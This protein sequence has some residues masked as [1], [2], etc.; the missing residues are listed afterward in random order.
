M[1]TFV[2]PRELSGMLPPIT[3]EEVI[4][5][6]RPPA[7]KPG[8]LGSIAQAWQ[9][10]NVRMSLAQVGLGLMRTPQ[11][12]QNSF[13]TASEALGLGLNTLQS[14]REQERQKKLQAEDRA[15]KEQQRQIENKRGDRQV[16]VQER[17]ATTAETNVKGDQEVKTKE[18]DRANR[19]LDEAIRHNK[20]QEEIDRLR[21][22]ADNLR[23]TAYYGNTQRTPAEIQ[24][25]NR[26]KAFYKQQDPNISDEIADKMAM[27]YLSTAKGK[28]PRQL[29][30]DAY[31]K[32]AQ[33]WM[34]QQYD[35][36]AQPTPEQQEQWKQQAINEVRFAEEAG[37]EVT[38]TRGRITRPTAPASTATPPAGAPP[39]QAATPNPI[40]QRNI[41]VWKQAQATSD[42]IRQLIKNR[43]EDPKIY[44]Y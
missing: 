37:Q 31:Q 9:D 38:D 11:M 5:M 1:A 35:P 32:K 36:A 30:I 40:T 23:A 19:A 6:P 8:F 14:L 21:A 3:Q 10:P 44:G 39:A 7:P 15:T 17:N 18:L 26:L 25:I 22:V 16:A 27:D 4:A 43:G 12:G 13:D 41:E 33:M 42:Q 34:E 24:K 28:S 20:S 29:V 2:D